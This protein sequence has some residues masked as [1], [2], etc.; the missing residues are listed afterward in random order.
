MYISRRALLASVWALGA[1][2]VARAAA[3]AARPEI[4]VHKSPTC[5]CC[6]QWVAHLRASGFPVRVEDHDDLSAVKRR[7]AVPTG[8]QSC[9]TALVEGYV[10]EGHVPADVIDQLLR[11]RPR[12]AGVAVPGMPIG[13]PGMEVPGRLAERYQVMTFDRDG[14]TTVYA[15]R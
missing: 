12:V 9:H 8:L 11:E 7:H 13:S 2:A 4:T 1:G 5:G 3:A 15:S 6:A 14:H 10:V